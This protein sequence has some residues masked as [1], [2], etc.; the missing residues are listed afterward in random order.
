MVDVLTN[1]DMGIEHVQAGHDDFRG[2]P[3]LIRHWL[4]EL[5]GKIAKQDELLE[6][7]QNCLVTIEARLALLMPAGKSDTCKLHT[8]EIREIKMWK[9]SFNKRAYM[10]M[11]GA[12]VVNILIGALA[13][14][15]GQ[16]VYQLF[17]LI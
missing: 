8:I 10:V 17:K 5:D 2:N 14:Y 1:N 7:I 6:K 3:D 11:G 4:G 15:I 13:W 9:E 16:K 12:F